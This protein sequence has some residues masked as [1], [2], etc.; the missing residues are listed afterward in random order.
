MDDQPVDPEL[1]PPAA[2]VAAP[3]TEP[4]P[5]A[6]RPA[7]VRLAATALV[8]AAVTIAALFGA[9]ARFEER[10]PATV[11]APSAS[12]ASSVGPTT[13][14]PIDGA[15]IGVA[16]PLTIEIWAD[17][18][19]PYCAL[20]S[21]AI[22]PALVREYAAAGTGQL[23]FRDFAFLGRESLDAAVA[24]RCAGRQ[25]QYWRYHDLLFA[26]QQGENQGAFDRPNLLSLGNFAGLDAARFHACLDDPTVAAAVTAETSQGRGYGIE[27]TPT[28]RIASGTHSELIRGI[29]DH[30][31]IAAAVHRVAL[32]LP[33]PTPSPSSPASGQP[34][35]SADAAPSE[36]PAAAN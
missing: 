28:L 15:R 25:D 16:A 2:S 33:A 5:R 13:G 24:A 12:P 35:P 32:G 30:A 8:A 19:C 17:Y 6:Q 29:V 1:T 10:D 27:S 18:Q 3:A 26:S 21:H 23:V 14:L 20:L 9:G 36:S 22:E 4:A 11:A 31:T 34:S 7:F